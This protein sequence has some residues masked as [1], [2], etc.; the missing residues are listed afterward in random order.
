MEHSF[1]SYIHLQIKSFRKNF[2][3]STSRRNFNEIHDYRVALKRIRTIISFIQRIPGGKNLKPCYTI[4]NLHLAFKSGGILR[5]MQIN[6][7]I[8]KGYEQKRNL[9]YTGFRKYIRQKEKSALKELKIAR[10]KFSARKIIKFEANLTGA[11]QNILPSFILENIDLFI[12][13][14][15]TQIKNLVKSGNVESTLH[16]IRRQTKSIKCPYHAWGYDLQGNLKNVPFE[17]DFEG[18]KKV[19]ALDP[20]LKIGYIVAK[21]IGNM[22]RIDTDLLSLN[23]GMVTADLVAG[24][25]KRK[26]EVHVWTI[27]TTDNMSYFINL[28]VDN[29]ITDYPAK[30]VA[31]INERD[32]LNDT[33]KLLLVAADM[34]KR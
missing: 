34:L 15:I 19:R 17:R 24:A 26:R 14:R 4:N 21:V 7:I 32:S 1:I 11:I 18:L 10:N 31:L 2:I 5:E 12:E 22:F 9:T 33:E 3:H 16:R 27:N 8:L 30:L 29:I 13:K 28:G 6:R 20:E 25:R 23:S